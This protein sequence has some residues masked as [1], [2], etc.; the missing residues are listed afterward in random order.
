MR[1]CPQPGKSAWA[2]ERTGRPSCSSIMS[3]TGANQIQ[4]TEA[5]TPSLPLSLCSNPASHE[6]AGW[7][8]AHSR[9]RDPSHWHPGPSFDSGPC[10]SIKIQ[11]PL[12]YLRGGETPR[13][14]EN[15]PAT[16]SCALSGPRPS[17]RAQRGTQYC[18][19]L[20]EESRRLSDPRISL[21]LFKT[22]ALSYCIGY[23]EK[24]SRM[25]YRIFHRPAAVILN[26]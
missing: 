21:K 17:R 1:N 5:N 8:H 6:P 7:C 25:K 10:R 23:G 24:S 3:M 19:R 22:R 13:E 12:F 14:R 16:R 9:Q 26:C 2:S 18:T 20:R 11:R 15:S 4:H